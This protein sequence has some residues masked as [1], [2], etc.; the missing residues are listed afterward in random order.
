MSLQYFYEAHLDE[1]ALA[2]SEST[3]HHI[4]HVLRMKVNDSFF[5]TDGKGMR[6]TAKIN[7]ISK[8]NISV[9]ATQ[10]E[11]MP[12][13]HAHLHLAIS[14]TKNSSRMEWLLE[15]VTEMG[16]E[17]ITPLIT[18]RSQFSLHK[19]ERFEKIIQSAMLQSQQVYMPTLQS[20]IPFEKLLQSH[21]N[22]KCIAYCGTEF[23]LNP[24]TAVLQKAQPTLIL[25]GPEGDFTPFEVEQALAHQFQIVHLGSNRLRTETAGLVAC[26]AYNLQTIE[27]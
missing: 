26:T 20:A 19:M 3:A 4:I 1:N 13:R 6:I 12:P 7:D 23:P 27:K 9:V 22:I 25:I 8:K 5:I 21:E 16:I 15:K 11:H 17:K 10:K 24:I 14:F 18:Q 2:L